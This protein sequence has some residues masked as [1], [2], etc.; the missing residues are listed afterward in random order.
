MTA[1]THPPMT[2]QPKNAAKIAVT[3][4]AKPSDMP[5]SQKVVIVGP[6]MF[7]SPTADGVTTIGARK[8][9]I[10]PRTRNEASA[11]IQVAAWAGPRG[12]TL[13]APLPSSWRRARPE[14]LEL[15]QGRA[16]ELDLLAVRREVAVTQRRLGQ[17]V[18]QVRVLDQRLDVGLTAASLRGPVIRTAARSR[19]GSARESAGRL[20]R[21]R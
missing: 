17:L 10:P 8:S 21:S 3:A 19:P 14:R 2:S 16:D 13:R 4:V 18:M 5:P 7:A 11:T 9:R 1:A 6:R 15:L 20:T 12:A